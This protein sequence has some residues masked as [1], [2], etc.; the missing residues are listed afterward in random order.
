MALILILL[1]RPGVVMASLLQAHTPGFHVVATRI[2]AIV[3]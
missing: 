1:H 2:S 3:A